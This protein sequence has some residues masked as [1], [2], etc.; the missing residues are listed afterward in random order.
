MRTYTLFGLL[1]LLLNFAVAQ[2][3]VNEADYALTIRRATGPITL[4]G[5]L[6]EADWQ[7][8][9]SVGNF[10]QFFPYDSSV[11]RA[12]TTV[13]RSMLILSTSP[14]NVSSRAGT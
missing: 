2:P 1:L 12:K 5:R 8:A 3:G 6:D 13:R 14:P 10:R 11:A 7:R 4:D 9:D